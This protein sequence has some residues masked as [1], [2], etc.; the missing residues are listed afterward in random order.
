MKTTAVPKFTPGFSSAPQWEHGSWLHQRRALKSKRHDSSHD[1]SHDIEGERYSNNRTN[2]LSKACWGGGWP[3]ASAKPEAVAKTWRNRKY[4]KIPSLKSPDVSP[5][6]SQIAPANLKRISQWC[7]GPWMMKLDCLR[8][9][10]W[11]RLLQHCHS[12]PYTLCIFVHQLCY[13]WTER[14]WDIRLVCRDYYAAHMS[15]MP[16]MEVEIQLN[17]IVMVLICSV[18]SHLISKQKGFWLL[19]ACCWS[20]VSWC[21]WLIVVHGCCR[22]CF[23][24]L[25]QSVLL[26]R[27]LQ[28]PTLSE[29]LLNWSWTVHLRRR[30]V[31][32]PAKVRAKSCRRR[33]CQ[34]LR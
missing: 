12:G 13:F 10:Q 3:I 9:S 7:H 16:A 2:P 34:Q 6:V 25:L 19:V 29:H 33:S 20:L 32:F 24:P 31:P 4:M 30:E 5:D 11:K 17:V 23:G 14:I 8:Q 26:L 21:C 1:I 22:C 27:L 28:L 15:S 18:T